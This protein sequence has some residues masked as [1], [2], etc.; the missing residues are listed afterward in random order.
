M[1]IGANFRRLADLSQGSLVCLPAWRLCVV[2][3]FSQRRAV[4][5]QFRAA[6]SWLFQRWQRQHTTMSAMLVAM[7]AFP[8]RL[9]LVGLIIPN[10]LLA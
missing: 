3:V 2:G 1:E 5:K 9:I 7:A 10:S 6:T 8:Q 4:T